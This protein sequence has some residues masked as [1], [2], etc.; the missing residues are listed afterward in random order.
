MAEKGEEINLISEKSDAT[1]I[2]KEPGDVS[3]HIFSEPLN[4]N[5]SF[6]AKAVRI[7]YT[8]SDDLLYSMD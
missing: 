2:W 6:I 1:I 7:G 4:K 8:D 5:V 3:W